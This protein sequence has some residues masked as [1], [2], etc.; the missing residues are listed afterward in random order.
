MRHNAVSRTTDKEREDWFAGWEEFQKLSRMLMDEDKLT[1]DEEDDDLELLAEPP[2]SY[3]ATADDEQEDEL[4]E[5]KT[6]KKKKPDCVRGNAAHRAKDGK[7]AHKG[8]GSS[9]SKQ[10]HK[11]S[12][13][14][15]QH[16]SKRLP[17]KRWTK[18][19][20]G[21]K[22]LPNG[23]PDPK[24]NKA[25]YRCHDGKKVREQRA[26]QALAKLTQEEGTALVMEVVSQVVAT[27]T[28][29]E[30]RQDELAVACK[31]GGFYSMEFFLELQDKLAQSQEGKLSGK[32]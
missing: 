23:K 29:T 4:L 18:V 27:S 21:R 10:P 5:K 11:G 25:D 1:Q 19:A 24:G 26:R 28:L 13:A 14:D 32:E 20:C 17:G 22:K 9:W 2:P 8:K 15:C 6:K 16:G 31:R 12:R 30:G 3:D 7:F